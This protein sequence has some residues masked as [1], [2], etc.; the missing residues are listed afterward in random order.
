DEIRSLGVCINTWQV[1]GFRVAPL[2]EPIVIRRNGEVE[3]DLGDDPMIR[4]RVLVVVRIEVCDLVHQTFS[5]H[6]IAQFLGDH[7]E[8]VPVVSRYQTAQFDS[9]LEGYVAE[10]DR[11]VD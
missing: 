11:G 10:S 4:S 3:W 1:A 9:M 2:E 7:Q 8:G 5:S 6:P